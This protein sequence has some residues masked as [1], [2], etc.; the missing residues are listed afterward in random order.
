ML[1]HKQTQ[2]VGKTGDGVQTPLKWSAGLYQVQGKSVYMNI[3]LLEVLTVSKENYPNR[4]FRMSWHLWCKPLCD[5]LLCIQF[6]HYFW[7]MHQL[8]S[9]PNA[10]SD[11]AW[12]NVI[13]PYFFSYT[14]IVATYSCIL[15][16]SQD[17]YVSTISIILQSVVGDPSSLKIVPLI[18]VK[19]Q[20]R[21]L[22]CSS[23][24]TRGLSQL[25][26]WGQC[27]EQIRGGCLTL[28]L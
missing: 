14:G 6:E 12:P 5:I 28:L 10:C 7:K 24:A 8:S 3:W 19:T 1:P 13:C 4:Q 21:E 15:S 18:F 2:C 25:A 9:V 22:R 17:I 27:V 20:L 16:C 26:G 23:D 11:E